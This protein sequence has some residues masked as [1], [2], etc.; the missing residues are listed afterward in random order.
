MPP[1]TAVAPLKAGRC[2]EAEKSV[3]AEMLSGFRTLQEEISGVPIPL[4][5]SHLLVNH[6][7][8]AIGHKY[9]RRDDLSTIHERCAI[10]PRRDT[11][12]LTIHGSQSRVLSECPATSTD[13]KIGSV[14]L[15]DMVLHDR[16]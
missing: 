2:V 5:R 4:K 9:I 1:E 6:V 13:V 14:A 3:V 11:D 7:D 16:S 8:D 15:H 10:A 12:I